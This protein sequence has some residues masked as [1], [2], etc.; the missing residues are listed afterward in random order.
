[1][2]RRRSRRAMA[3][4][5]GSGAARERING[6]CWCGRH[7]VSGGRRRLERRRRRRRRWT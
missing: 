2:S 6:D 3:R 1:V 5:C 7:R 4:S